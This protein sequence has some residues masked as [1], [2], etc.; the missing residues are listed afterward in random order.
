M[1]KLFAWTMLCG[2]VV[3]SAMMSIGCSGSPTTKPPETKPA[4]DNTGGKKD[5]TKDKTGK[6]DKT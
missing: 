1:K 3:A 5:D 4:G 2:F 6:T